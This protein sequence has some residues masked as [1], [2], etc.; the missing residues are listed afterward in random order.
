[1]LA[2]VSE[3]AICQ[4]S[5]CGPSEEESF[6]MCDSLSPFWNHEM[7]GIKENFLSNFILKSLIEK[8]NVGKSNNIINYI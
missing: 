6:G 4:E 8:E 1:M 3:E 2:F 5:G 7:I